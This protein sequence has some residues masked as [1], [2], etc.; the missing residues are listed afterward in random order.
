[1]G[2]ICEN[3]GQI[4]TSFLEQPLKSIHC[5]VIAKSLCVTM[6]TIDMKNNISLDTSASF[7]LKF[8]TAVGIYIVCADD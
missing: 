1:M 2:V 4:A 7:D 8:S 6:A 5:L 3:R